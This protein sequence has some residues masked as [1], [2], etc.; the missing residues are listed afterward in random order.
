MCKKEGLLHF[1]YVAGNKMCNKSILF[2]LL[3][4]NCIRIDEKQWEF[5]AKTIIE[6]KIWI[7]ANNHN[8]LPCYRSGTSGYEY[9]FELPE[10]YRCNYK[11]MDE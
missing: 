8:A 6:P 11:S 3:W 4:E 9:S 2:A 5:Y 7:K 10:Y 1:L